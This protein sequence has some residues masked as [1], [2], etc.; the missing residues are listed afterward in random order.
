[1]ADLK[2][3]V[4]ARLTPQAI[5]A[6][7]EAVAGEP[8]RRSGAEYLFPCPDCTKDAKYKC[9][10]T[11]GPAGVMGCF[12]CGTQGDD[13]FAAV[14]RFCGLPAGRDGF[15]EALDKIAGILNVRAG[16]RARTP[17]P[18]AAEAED[19]QRQQ[20]IARALEI[21]NEARPDDRSLAYFRG[22]GIEINELPACIRF[23][24]KAPCRVKR[25]GDW[26]NYDG[27]AVVLAHVD[28]EGRQRAI[29]IIYLAADNTKRPEDDRWGKPKK[30]IGDPRGCA[31]RFG[32]DFAAGTLVLAEG[33][34]TALAVHRATGLPTWC[35][36][37]T[38]G[39]QNVV[40]PADVRR[41]IHRVCIAADRDPVLTAGT[42][43]GTRP[44]ER[45]ARTAAQRLLSLYPSLEVGL[46]IPPGDDADPASKADWLDVY[47]TEGG[48]DVI[49][50]ALRTAD[51]VV[52]Q[53][54]PRE[55]TPDGNR[56]IDRAPLMPESELERARMYLESRWA[57]AQ[58]AGESL[59]LVYAIGQFWR[60]QA[61]AY[62]AIGEDGCVRRDVRRWMESGFAELC[63]RS[64]GRG[65]SPVFERRWFHAARRSV[66]AVVEAVRDEVR[67]DTDATRFWMR[68]HFDGRGSVSYG[69][70]AW[71]R[72]DGDAP[73]PSSV[74]A[75]RNCL[76]LLGPWLADGCVEIVDH[77]PRF[78]NTILLDADLPISDMRAH[79]AA[80]TLEEL[81][82]RLAPRW[83]RFLGEVFEDDEECILTL[84]MWFGY[85]M[86][87]DV[88][89]EYANIL[90]LHGPPRCGKGTIREALCGVIGEN[91]F[92]STR[93]DKLTDGPH[94]Y[95]WVNKLIAVFP[96]VSVPQRS[97]AKLAVEVINSITG[98]DPIPIRQ[99]Y[100]P[101]LPPVKL[102]T[103]MLWLCNEMPDLRDTANAL[104]ARVITLDFRQSWE[105][106]EDPEVKRS[107]GREVLGITLWALLGLR[108]LHRRGRMT[109]P[110]SSRDP[111]DTWRGHTSPVEEFVSDVLEVTNED[112][113]WV[114]SAEVFEAWKK[115]CEG[116]NQYIGSS[117]VLFKRLLA[118][119]RR[120]EFGWRG[121]RVQRRFGFGDRRRYGYSGLR[122]ALDLPT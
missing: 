41:K 67:V 45:C 27:P 57:P 2:E 99:L 43:A 55:R 1:M 79:A 100:M 120:R 24:P 78:F 26:H 54:P 12:G 82:G 25:D 88:S 74:I 106:R 40:V 46:A 103:R 72:I 6:V 31:V 83:L 81:V 59:R 53:E 85:A 93:I 94:M 39:L 66:E 10:P 95:S 113:D 64:G 13:L 60:H 56:D 15:K 17:R 18:R 3:Q 119:L 69:G 42:N 115:H 51:N 35:C 62:Q 91:N 76:L 109:Q 61:C 44:G 101:E 114:G 97:D 92:V 102:L 70:H 73:E 112:E 4:L 47:T 29:Q 84:Q 50:E 77:T 96:E 20:R 30:T 7:L 121:R 118:V 9:T 87:A 49:R 22:R 122:I 86:T 110:E 90:I 37:S 36:L 80:G 116:E 28:A 63:R 32:D 98:G 38:A 34:E 104:P 68:P 8:P 14:A 71:E 5:V 23:H 105:G 58:A 33:P 89:H 107:I 65:N 108:E 117:D 111:L 19:S 52:R 11:K 21:W 16:D 75:F 48:P